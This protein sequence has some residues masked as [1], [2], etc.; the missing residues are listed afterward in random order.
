MIKYIGF[1]VLFLLLALPLIQAASSTTETYFSVIEEPELQIKII[2]PIN[3]T[4][5]TS[6]TQIKIETNIQAKCYYS[7]N[8]EDFVLLGDSTYFEKKLSLKN[9]NYELKILCKTQYQEKEEAINFEVDKEE[10]Q[11]TFSSTE[12][13][14]QNIYNCTSW[15]CKNGERVRTCQFNTCQDSFIQTGGLC[16]EAQNPDSKISSKTSINFYNLILILLILI[17]IV[18]VLLVYIQRYY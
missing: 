17:L 11:N 12:P 13:Q 7:L 6:I 14:C 4:Y 9:G 2:S 1:F 5:H 10:K 16:E 18:I 3:T 8:S 15:T